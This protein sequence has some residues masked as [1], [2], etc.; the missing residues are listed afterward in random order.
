MISF[1]TVPLIIAINVIIFIVWSF[2][3]GSMFMEQNF[4]VSWTS[5]LEGRYWVL[6][7]SVFSHNMFWHLLMNMFVLNSFGP[8]VEK[9]IGLSRFI[10]FY[11]AAGIIS[12]LAH[13]LVSA[14]ILGQPELSALGASG[15]ISGIVI[16]FSLLY[17]EQKILIFGI[18]P[19]PAML[20]A[21]LFVGIDIWGLV[22]Q[23]GGSGLPIGHGAH[24]GGA[25]AG[26]LYYLFYL[27]RLTIR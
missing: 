9:T 7:T 24:L 4:L 20:G 3:D 21:I 23:A 25:L 2:L 1:S 10:K 12:S 13:A 6:V 15:S 14:W 11:F 17:P 18:I 26:A 16:L 19:M 8:I 5:L 22:V 27:R